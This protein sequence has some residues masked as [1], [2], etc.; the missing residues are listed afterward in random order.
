MKRMIC[1]LV[2]TVMLIVLPTSPV[3][4]LSDPFGI[5][6]VHRDNG[7]D[8]PWGGE[9]H[10]DEDDNGTA[11]QGELDF[12]GGISGY[13]GIDIVNYFFGFFVD[14]FAS[15]NYTSTKRYVIVS[16]TDQTQTEEPTGTNNHHGN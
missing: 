6:E 14:R 3:Y 1:L 13:L 12:G 4:S 5:S 10:Y 9:D 11:V 7:E 8:H 16:T 2:L 15:D